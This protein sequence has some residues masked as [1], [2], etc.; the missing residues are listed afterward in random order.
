M[1]KSQ[2][3]QPQLNVRTKEDLGKD[4]N[5]QNFIRSSSSAPAESTDCIAASKCPET[6]SP[7]C[8]S[9]GV[10]YGNECLL[11]STADCLWEDGGLLLEGK[12]VNGVFVKDFQAVLMLLSHW[13]R[14]PT[15]KS[16]KMYKD[17]S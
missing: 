17:W 13:I 11:L 6:L 3:S 5:F 16:Q 2:H 7:V 15:L 9:N 10:T 12:A 14:V 8:G 4:P 1:N